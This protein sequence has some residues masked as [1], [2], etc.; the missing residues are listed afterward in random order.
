[1]TGAPWSA[2]QFRAPA[3]LPDGTFCRRRRADRSYEGEWQAE[4]PAGGSHPQDGHPASYVTTDAAEFHCM[5]VR[6][7]VLRRLGGL[8]EN[9]LSTRENIDLCL[10][11]RELG[12]RSTLNRDPGLPTSHPTHWRSWIYRSSRFDGAISGTCRVSTIC[13]T[14]GNSTRQIFPPPVCESRLAAKGIDD[15]RQPAPVAGLVAPAH[16]CGTNAE[17]IGA[18][19]ECRDCAATRHAIRRSPATLKATDAFKASA[20]PRNRRKRSCGGE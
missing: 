7:D 10:A 18:E 16:G 8:D 4:A 20:L 13:G 5:L 19:R 11:L 14:N 17:A 9:M 2:L 15:A 6:T 3:A 12:R 1:M